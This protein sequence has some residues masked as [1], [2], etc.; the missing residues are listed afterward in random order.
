MVPTYNPIEKVMVDTGDTRP[1]PRASS[2]SGRAGLRREA[3]RIP[4]PF[5]PAQ[6]QDHFRQ[7]EVHAYE[8]VLGEA[9]IQGRVLGEM[10]LV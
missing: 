2:S 6:G 8:R 3:H 10:A 9:Y 7:H 4:P 1:T 5:R